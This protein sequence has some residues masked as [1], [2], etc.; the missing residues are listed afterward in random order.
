MSAN[1]ACQLWHHRD[2]PHT[3]F[4]A[5]LALYHKSPAYAR[6]F[7]GFPLQVLIFF[8]NQQQKS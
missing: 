2:K 4:F 1:H 7:S 5:T 8:Q 3:C 6:L